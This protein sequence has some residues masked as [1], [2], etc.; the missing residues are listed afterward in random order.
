METAVNPSAIINAWQDMASTLTGSFETSVVNAALS[1]STVNVPTNG[2]CTANEGPPGPNQP[3]CYS[4]GQGTV[5]FTSMKISNFTVTGPAAATVS[6][7]TASLPVSVSAI[8]MS[9]NYNYNQPCTCEYMK[10]KSG[11]SAGSNGGVTQSFGSCEIVFQCSIGADGKL[12]LLSASI[13]GSPSTNL[14]PDNGG[15]PSWLSSLIGYVS[16]DSQVTQDV[17][18]DVGNLFGQA[19][20]SQLLIQKMNAVL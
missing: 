5:A 6:G 14:S 19:S 8:E 4:S 20:F 1:N 12:T 10:A 15:L 11:S 9:G 3:T 7:N 17:S 13:A 16:G 18:Q 2:S